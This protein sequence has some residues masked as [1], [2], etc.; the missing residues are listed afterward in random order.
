MIG[1]HSSSLTQLS[2]YLPGDAYPDSPSRKSSSSRKCVGSH[3]KYTKIPQRNTTHEMTKHREGEI[4]I[5]SGQSVTLTLTLSLSIRHLTQYV[6]EPQQYVLTLPTENARSPIRIFVLFTP[7]EGRLRVIPH[8][9]KFKGFPGLIHNVTL[10]VLSTFARPVHLNS[11]EAGDKRLTPVLTTQKIQ[12]NV[13]VRSLSLSH[14]T[15]D[16]TQC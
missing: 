1:S 6:D 4:R 14:C 13:E 2:D 7:V 15:E 5:E 16:S 12:P 3:I 11:I 8:V 9:M 10:K